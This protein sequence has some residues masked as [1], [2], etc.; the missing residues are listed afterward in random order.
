MCRKN[1]KSPYNYTKEEIEKIIENLNKE[2]MEEIKDNRRK[3][4]VNKR[5]SKDFYVD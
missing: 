2:I 4:I 3:Q 1:N 5:L